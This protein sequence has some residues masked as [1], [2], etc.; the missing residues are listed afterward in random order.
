MKNLIKDGV[1][2]A[3]NWQF[4]RE[5]EELEAAKASGNPIFIAAELWADLKGQLEGVELGVILNSDQPASLIA[6]D[7]DKLKAVAI[8][9]PVF[10]DG[11]GFSYARELRETHKFDG[12]IRAVGAF[13][14]DQLFYLK[15]CGINA[16]QFDE[17]ADLEAAIA[18]LSDFSD[19][20]QAAV[21]Q[22]EPLFLRR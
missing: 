19:S 12:E 14:R 1:V 5:A 9:F 6:E 20:Y 15:R 7:L 21:D 16:F 22:A 10:V 18:S 13:I 8:N 4:V 17:E 2:V 11:R 3:D